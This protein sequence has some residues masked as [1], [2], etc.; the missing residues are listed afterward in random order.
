[1]CT[2]YTCPALKWR[3]LYCQFIIWNYGRLYVPIYL[4]AHMQ[5]ET[6]F[7]TEGK[8]EVAALDSCLTYISSSGKQE[9][10][11][12]PY[13]AMYKPTFFQKNDHPKLEGWPLCGAELY[14]V[15][16]VISDKRQMVCTR[17]PVSR[18]AYETPKSS[19]ENSN[20]MLFTWLVRTG[21]HFLRQLIGREKACNYLPRHASF[22]NH[23]LQDHWQFTLPLVRC[24][25]CECG[26]QDRAYFFLSISNCFVLLVLLLHCKDFIALSY[27]CAAMLFREKLQNKARR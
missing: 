5:L 19:K 6:S 4:D 9:S 2:Q 20:R 1:M 25:S 23:K 3:K 10:V 24:A 12:L 27:A 8:E 26:R 17:K 22:R 16:K 11:Q 7:C 21:S 13:L 14:A 15:S 18:K